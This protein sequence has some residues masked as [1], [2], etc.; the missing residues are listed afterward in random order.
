MSILWMRNVLVDGVKRSLYV[1]LGDKRIGDKCYTRI[2]DE[3]EVWFYNMFDTRHDVLAQG[4]DILKDKLRYSSV[5]H[6]DGTHFRWED[7]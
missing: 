7:E 4:L 6:P 3:T 2:G 5:V 1:Q